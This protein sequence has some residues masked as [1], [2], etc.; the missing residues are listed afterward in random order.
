[1]NG[2]R[3]RSFQMVIGFATPQRAFAGIG[4]LTNQIQDDVSLKELLS[5]TILVHSS[6]LPAF[7][8]NI[9]LCLVA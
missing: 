5:P 6:N 9:T 1:M 4:L 3:F 8:C 7:T 2:L